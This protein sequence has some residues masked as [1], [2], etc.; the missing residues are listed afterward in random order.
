LVA[1][2]SEHNRA[3]NAASQR[4][5]VDGGNVTLG[6]DNKPAFS[7]VDFVRYREARIEAFLDHCILQMPAGMTAELMRG[8]YYPG[9][10]A[11][12]DRAA[13]MAEDESKAGEVATKKSRA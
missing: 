1:L 2:P 12:Y 13:D 9:L 8:D 7:G 6:E 4:A 10:C 11:L 5:L 3:F